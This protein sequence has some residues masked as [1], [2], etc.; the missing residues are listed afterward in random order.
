MS[1]LK[2]TIGAD[3]TQLVN[4]VNQA[5]QTVNKVLGGGGSGSGA[6]G[7]SGSA[8][9]AGAGAGGSAKQGQPGAGIM[10]GL[11]FAKDLLNGQIASA[12]GGAIGSAFGP[13][14]AAIGEKIGEVVDILIQKVKQLLDQAIQLRNL[15]LQTG[16]TTQQIQ[17]LEVVAQSTGISVSR[18]ADSMSEF[19]RRLGYARTHGGEM[20]LLLNKL[21]VSMQQIRDGTFSYF[22][23]IE[24]LRKAQAAGTEEA[25]LNH[26]AQVML[27]STYKDLL[28]LIKTGSE[29]LRVYNERVYKVSKDSMSNL[30]EAGDAWNLFTENVKN[31]TMDLLGRLLGLLSPS[32]TDIAGQMM[33]GS[34]QSIDPTQRTPT[35]ESADQMIRR[36]SIALGPMEDSR[37]RQLLQ[38]AV[39]VAGTQGLSVSRQRELL[40]AIDRL[41]PNANAANRLSALGFAPAQGASQ[42]QQMGGGDIFGAMTFDP[43]RETAE[44]TRRTADGID[45]LIRPQVNNPER[46]DLNT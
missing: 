9:N 17:E 31:R 34:N 5:G 45:I 8:G 13:L 11:N 44:N 22:D 29:N 37:R 19:S 42:M 10:G 24:A 2:V 21:G 35:G 41:I 39:T 14:G 27:G 16:L 12:L 6:G 4:A 7:A 28:P 25:I 1:D 30:T 15:S 26:Y 23:A 38:E 3:T 43:V 40:S 36:I 18:L 20:N 32:T 46:G 33:P